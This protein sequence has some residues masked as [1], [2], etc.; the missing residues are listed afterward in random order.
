MALEITIDAGEP[1]VKATYRL[2]S[3]LT[4][5]AHEKVCTIYAT[6]SNVHHPSTGAVAIKMSANRPV[7]NNN[8]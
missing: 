2:D 3:H 8:L 6:I 4:F 1:F 7:L 5:S